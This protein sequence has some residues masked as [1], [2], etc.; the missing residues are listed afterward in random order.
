MWDF[1]QVIGLVGAI[2]LGVVL[3]IA[4]L[5]T[6]ASVLPDAKQA[7]RD[8]SDNLTNNSDGGW[9][10][11]LADS[12]AAG[13]IGGLAVPLSIMLGVVGGIFG[14]IGFLI[15]RHTRKS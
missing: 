3:V 2:I 14:A 12:L 1:K 8:I 6:Y 10:S 7:S 5:M 15:Y 13:P 11:D 9:G 4:G